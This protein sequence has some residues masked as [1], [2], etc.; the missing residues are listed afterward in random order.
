MK[1]TISAIAMRRILADVPTIA[2]VTLDSEKQEAIILDEFGGEKR[3]PI[4]IREI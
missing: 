4:K 3:V 1:L 2:A